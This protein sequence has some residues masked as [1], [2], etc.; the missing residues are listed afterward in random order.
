MIGSRFF[1]AAKPG[2]GHQHRWAVSLR[3]HQAQ[4]PEGAQQR[5]V[6][7]TQVVEQRQR[8]DTDDGQ[9]EQDAMAGV[10]VVAVA[11]AGAAHG[12]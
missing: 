12:R 8:A 3:L 5:D 10:L 6:E 2:I 1:R 7:E 11:M 4:R 9:A